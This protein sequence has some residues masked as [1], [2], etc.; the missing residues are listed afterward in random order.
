MRK[1]LKKV[2]KASP[3]ENCSNQSKTALK[4]S[5]RNEREGVEKRKG[6]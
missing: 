4:K 2:K 1:V 5:W 6:E 3:G